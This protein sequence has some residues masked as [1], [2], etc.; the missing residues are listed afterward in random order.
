MLFLKTTYKKKRM[1]IQNE[2]TKQNRCRVLWWIKRTTMRFLSFI[3]ASSFLPSIRLCKKNRMYRFGIYF[4]GGFIAIIILYFSENNLGAIWKEEWNWTKGYE[5][6]NYLAAGAT[7]ILHESCFLKNRYIKNRENIQNNIFE[8]LEK[9][10]A[11]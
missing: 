9:R 5:R 10:I 7:R 1:Q 8:L 2:K 4:Q 6:Y 11:A 3:S